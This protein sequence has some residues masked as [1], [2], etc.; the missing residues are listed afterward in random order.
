[1]VTCEIVKEPENL[2]EA[3][4]WPDWPIWQQAMN[5]EMEQHQEIGTWEPV[6]LPT[7]RTTIGCR[8][9]YMVKTTPSND[10]DKVKAH[11]VLKDLPKDLEWT[12][13]TSLHQ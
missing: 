11:L 5:V 3:E 9:V 6:E 7:G 1:M 2:K 13:M 12:T 8:W 10:F 4:G